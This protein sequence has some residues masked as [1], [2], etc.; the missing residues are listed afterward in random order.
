M[1]NWYVVPSDD[2][3]IHY[4]KKGMRWGVRNQKAYQ[5]SPNKVNKKKGSNIQ[6]KKS[7]SDMGLRDYNRGTSNLIYNGIM[8][9]GELDETEK[10]ISDAETTGVIKEQ[11]MQLIL[12]YLNNVEDSTRKHFLEIVKDTTPRAYALIMQRYKMKK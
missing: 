9:I 10:A 6:L 1:S 8:S 7:G 11:D 4:G 5:K 3:I 12:K 2:D